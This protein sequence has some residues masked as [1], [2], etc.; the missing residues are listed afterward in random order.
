MGQFEFRRARVIHIPMLNLAVIQTKIELFQILRLDR[1]VQPEVNR[2]AKYIEKGLDPL[3]RYPHLKM[4]L[5]E[6]EAQRRVLDVADV[7][8]GVP[9]ERLGSVDSKVEVGELLDLHKG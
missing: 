8:L 1:G 7:N 3:I 2:N 6:S 4:G 9:K 5:L